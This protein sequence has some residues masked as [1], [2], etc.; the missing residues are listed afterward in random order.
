MPAS[1]RVPERY[2]PS[3]AVYARNLAIGNAKTLVDIKVV[4]ITKDGGQGK[5]VTLSNGD[6]ITCRQ[7]IS[8]S[9]S[10]ELGM[11]PGVPYGIGRS[12]SRLTYGEWQAGSMVTG[13]NLKPDHIRNAKGDIW[14]GFQGYPHHLPG[15]A[16]EGIQGYDYR[17]TWCI[18]ERRRVRK[19]YPRYIR[20]DGLPDRAARRNDDHH[21]GLRL[22]CN[23][24]LPGCRPVGRV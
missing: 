20:E 15:Q 3:S 19:H 5:A 8:A 17:M 21:Q 12:E 10:A 16:D 11:A 6:T 13:G 7:M 23:T 24:L 18:D 4:G 22:P 9:Y 14:R 2:T 1:H